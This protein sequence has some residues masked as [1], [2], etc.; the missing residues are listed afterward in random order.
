MD[1]GSNFSDGQYV[2]GRTSGV[3]GRVHQCKDADYDSNRL[4]IL[5]P[6]NMCSTAGTPFSCCT[7]WEAGC[8]TA[9]TAT[10]YID[11]CNPNTA[12]CS[13]VNQ[14]QSWKATAMYDWTIRGGWSGGGIDTRYATDV[15]VKE[16]EAGYNEKVIHKADAYG[17][18]A[19]DESNDVIFRHCVAY[20]NH[21]SGFEFHNS[22]KTTACAAYNCLAYDNTD[23]ED[24]ANSAGFYLS[25]VGT[26]AHGTHK[27][28]LKNNVSVLDNI[29][30][31]KM[32]TSCDEANMTLENNCYWMGANT[33]TIDWEGT[34][35]KAEDVQNDTFYNAESKEHYGIGADP[36]I[37][38]L[39]EPIADRFKYYAGSP[40]VDA[41]VD[42]S[43][44]TALN[45]TAGVGGT[46][47]DYF[48]NDIPFDGDNQN[49]AQWDVG[50][51]ERQNTGG[52]IPKILNFFRRRI[53][54]IE[55]PERKAYAAEGEI[56]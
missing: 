28:I 19:D 1:A 48:G 2:K 7:G 9:F 10:E 29:Y 30:A 40:L 23:G 44:S 33:N 15:E 16:C 43:G 42:V 18:D 21:G 12:A 39:E 50:V 14:S 52:I 49:G 11:A 34:I 46:C 35:Y 8:S 6:Q 24:L 36:L 13:A 56:Q 17:F 37:V 3:V 26:G 45:C 55:L 38:A 31:L 51:W 47:K 4:A 53:G 20:K 5:D 32:A 27:A 25:C 41:G 22:G 54:K